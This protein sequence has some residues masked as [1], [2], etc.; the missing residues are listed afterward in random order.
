MKLFLKL[1]AALLVLVVVGAG[2]FLLTWD[3]PSPSATTT[4]VLPNDRFPS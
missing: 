1:F 2:A 3:I 4:I